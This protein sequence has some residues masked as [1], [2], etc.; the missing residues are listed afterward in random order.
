MYLV[1]FALAVMIFTAFSG[2]KR[3][4]VRGAVP[5]FA[6]AVLAVAVMQFSDN[7]TMFFVGGFVALYSAYAVARQCII[8][9]Y[10]YRFLPH[11]A[12]RYVSA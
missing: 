10:S 3:A 6:L 2:Q 4:R 12:R 11:G 8:R 5:L 7:V 1:P 9:P